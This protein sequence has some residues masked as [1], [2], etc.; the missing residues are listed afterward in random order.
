MPKSIDAVALVARRRG[1]RADLILP[2]TKHFSNHMIVSH[3]VLPYHILSHHIIP[4]HVISYPIFSYL[5]L[6]YL[7]LF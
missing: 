6:S 1:G 5:I 7:I 3:T 4:Y 2:D